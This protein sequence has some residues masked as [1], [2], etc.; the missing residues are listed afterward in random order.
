MLIDIHTDYNVTKLKI[1]YVT[2]KYWSRLNNTESKNA[3]YGLCN[4]TQKAFE[5][6]LK[7]KTF[8][9]IYDNTM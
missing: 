8:E 5:K 3:K 6:V 7:K 9:N 4:F 2:G 1:G